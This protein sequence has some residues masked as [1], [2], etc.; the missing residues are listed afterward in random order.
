MKRT[1]TIA[2]WKDAEGRQRY[3]ARVRLGDGSRP[4]IPVPDGYSEAR[5]REF[6]SHVQEQEDARG[7]LLAAKQARARERARVE[8]VACKGE[9]SDAWAERY[10]D[11]QRESGL[12]DVRTKRSRWMKWI[13]PRIGPKPIE[14]VTRDDIEDIRD[15][16][17]AAVRAWERE[18]RAE[19]RIGGKAVMNVWSCLTSAFKAATSSKRRDLRVLTANP[20]LG[21]EP[22][23]DAGSRKA[24]RKPFVYPRE[25]ADVF[26]CARIP[27]AWREVHAC[28]AMLYLRPGELRVLTV[29]DVS[30]DARIVNVTKAWDYT[31][32]EVKDP[33]TRNGVRRVPIEPA[34][35]PL[36][37][38]LVA[39]RAREELLL[40][41]VSSVPD[42]SLGELFREHLKLAGVDRPELHEATRTHVQGNFRSWRDSGITW[43]AMTGLG[44]DRIMRR[45]GHDE[46]STTMRYVKQAEDLGDALGVPF[47]PLPLSLVRST[48]RSTEDPDTHA[49]AEIPP[50]PQRRARDSN[51][52]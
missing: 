16:L 44:V 35:V 39:N 26:A 51:P 7:E 22:P 40:P 50:Q 8:R 33:K 45:A 37:E 3:R 52:W 4:W 17:D 12:T 32:A 28:A 23:G 38:R 13:S 5:A 25:A 18:G 24:R 15:A 1:G 29:G 49:V 20:T 42:N 6:A 48:G 9:T 19:D 43:L 36:L 30:L 21:V 27:M 46:V 41:V 34:L 11:F 10:F 31:E 47:G 2:P 14:A